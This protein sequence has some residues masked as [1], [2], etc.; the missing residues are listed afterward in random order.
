[1]NRSFIMTALL[2]ALVSWSASGV[3][4]AQETLPFPKA[5]TAS[6]AGKTLAE[7][8]HH[9]RQRASHLRKDAPNVLIIMLDDAGYAQADTVGGPI[10]TPTLSRIADSGV[11]YNHFNTTAICS[12]TRATLL[13]GR[14]QPRNTDGR[15]GGKEGVSKGK[16]G[17]SRR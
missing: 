17:W 12:S 5:P 9:W 16:L 15:S 1:M 3:V 6:T 8:T 13:T 4:D 11:R 7:S 2:G 14:K 10:H